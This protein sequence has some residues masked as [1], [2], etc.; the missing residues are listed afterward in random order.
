MCHPV[1]V[2]EG[3]QHNL[4]DMDV[5]ARWIASGDRGGDIILW[6]RT[7]G[8]E[9]HRL[10]PSDTEVTRI[11][12][13]PD[14]RILATAGQDRLVRLWNVD[15]WTPLGELVQHERTINGLAWSP[16]SRQIAS[17]DRDGVVC[18]WNVESRTSQEVLPRHVEAVR[19]LAWSLDGKRVATSDGD[20]GV[21]VWD[22]ETWSQTGFI[23]ND[24][25]GTLAIAFS[26]DSQYMAFG[27]YLG[28]LVVVDLATDLRVQRIQAP[29]Q[30]WSL[31]FGNRNELIAGGTF[32][33]LQHFQHSGEKQSWQ[34]VRFVDVASSGSRH[35]SLAYSADKQF[36]YIASEEDRLIKVLPMA[37][38]TG[39]A[40]TE[41][42]SVPIGVI[43]ELNYLV[44]TGRN[45]G[46]GTVRQANNNAFEFQLPIPIESTC[47]PEYSAAANLL[48]VAS[49]GPDRGQAYVFHASSWEIVASLE[50]PT[51]IRRL[52][53]S[54][55]GKLLV[56]TG[57]GSLVRIWDLHTNDYRDLT[58]DVGDKFWSMAVFSPTSDVLVHG[59]ASTQTLTCLQAVSLEEIR[60]V[61]AFSLWHCLHYSPDGNFLVVGGEDRISVW[62]PDLDRMLWTSTVGS[63]EDYVKSVSF[64]PDRRTI[65]ILLRDG[66]VRF[67]DLQ[68]RSELFSVPPLNPGRDYRWISFIDSATLLLGAES[69]SKIFSLSAAARRCLD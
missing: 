61:S 21:R 63:S 3:H 8:R 27:G 24:G 16:D 6:D 60:T 34:S 2:F 15:A 28:E 42:D 9:V 30:I 62:T 56:L 48:A 23:P 49:R 7:S 36:L 45:G 41:L 68:S 25:K 5:S 35:R 44:C 43:P 32:G 33:F 22:T 52:S 54:R 11:R 46:P 58:N 20:Q 57:E 50:F 26:T 51:H 14:G 55:D 53:F 1:Q 69:E 4:L 38:V 47:I 17:G 65:A 18:I 10:H 67:K 13:S 31:A 40:C 59:L 12:F 19:C 37:S 64:S 39:Y 66:T 29:M